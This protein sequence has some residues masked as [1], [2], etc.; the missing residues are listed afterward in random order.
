MLQMRK[1]RF[2]KPL[3]VLLG[4]PRYPLSLAASTAFLSFAVKETE[5][6]SKVVNEGSNLQH[7]LLY[8][9]G[10][11]FSHTKPAVAV[12]ARTHC[13]VLIPVRNWC[14]GTRASE[15]TC[16]SIASLWQ[17]PSFLAE[18]VRVR[19][20]VVHKWYVLWLG[21]L[22]LAVRT[23]ANHCMSLSLSCPICKKGVMIVV[24]NPKTMERIK[25]GNTYLSTVPGTQ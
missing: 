16:L 6:Q 22:I 7:Q 24:L 10:S 13:W 14:R 25:W 8:W 5:A 1:L 21:G 15:V 12:L 19:G 11:P 18:A 20:S 4:L 9:F 17:V 3:F 2:Q 23:W